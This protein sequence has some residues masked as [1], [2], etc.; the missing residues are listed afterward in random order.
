MS[1]ALNIAILANKNIGIQIKLMVNDYRKENM[2]KTIPSLKTERLLLRA[3][4][5]SDARDVLI[6]Y[7]DCSRFMKIFSEKKVQLTFTYNI[8]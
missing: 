1:L 6:G 4:V 3:F 2:K 7:I 8:H 5:I